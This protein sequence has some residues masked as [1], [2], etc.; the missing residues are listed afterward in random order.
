ME[1]NNPNFPPPPGYGQNPNPY[2]QNPNPYQ[3]AP[4]GYQQ[5]PGGYQQQFGGGY[6]GQID[7]PKASTINTLGIIGIILT[8]LIGIVGLVLN[9]INLSIS[10]S[11]MAD[12]RNNPGKYTEASI[13]KIKTGR[14][15]SIVGLSIQGALI[16]I[17]ILIIAAFN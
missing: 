1:N 8:F 4:G 11:V 13:K 16:L 3:Q 2:G 17:V 5:A 7:H 12:I 6:A 9:I 14:T 15:C 10:G